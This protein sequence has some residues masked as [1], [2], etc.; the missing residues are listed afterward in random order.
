M[1]DKGRTPLFYAALRNQL[2]AVTMLVSIGEFFQPYLSRYHCLI[3]AFCT[4]PQWIEVGDVR[5]DTPL[6]AA[7]ISDSAKVLEFFL[8]CEVNPDIANHIGLTC[9]HIGSSSAV[10][11][12]LY[13]WGGTLYCVDN[14]NRMPLFLA[15]KDGRPDCVNYLCRATPLEYILW[16]DGEGNN[17]LHIAAMNGH[18]KC[19][20]EICR[21]M[22]GVEN[23]YITNIKGYTAAHIASNQR[24]LKI[25]YENGADLWV[26]DAKGR[27][28]LFMAS[29]HGRFDCVMFF[30]DLALQKQ[31]DVVGNVD[32]SGDTALHAA[33]LC[34]H[35]R[36]VILLLYFL[37]DFPNHS[38]LT[39]SQLAARAKHQN[40]FDLVTSVEAQRNEGYSTFDILKCQIHDYLPLAQYYGS[41]WT[42]LYDVESDDAYY[43]DRVCGVS[44][45]DRP[46]IF[47]EDPK[48][49]SSRDVARGVLKQFYQKY[50]PEKLKDMN[51]KN[52]ISIDHCLLRHIFY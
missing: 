36:C 4:E 28:P 47:D 23:F 44:Q 39:P 22:T 5:G 21:W 24:V 26:R 51:G 50:N 43:F 7:A 6:H 31:E 1:D 14:E 17:C 34:G 12:L 37:R 41:R 49:E 19:V 27:F 18:D 46:A 15:C 11:D 52:N 35:I 9:A 45:W 2:A 38:G 13:R 32:L 3:L 48:E 42:K 20:E 29:F 30:L 8:S 16:A 33:C 10:L 40:V 25:L